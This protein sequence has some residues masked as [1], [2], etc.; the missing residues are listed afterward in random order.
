[1][2]SVDTERWP[3]VVYRFANEVTLTQLEAYL[4]RQEELLLRRQPSASLV[5]VESLRMWEPVVV[6]RQAAWIRDHQDELRR[7]SLGVALVLTSPVA[8]GILKAVLWMQPMPQPHK[9]CATIEE[10]L[11]WV[12]GRFANARIRVD[13]PATL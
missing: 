8:R 13:L 1:M 6:K 10:A 11:D 2:I 4:A 7:A 12:R 9:V 3:L 5:I